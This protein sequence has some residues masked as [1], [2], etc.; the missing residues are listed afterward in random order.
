M[1]KYAAIGTSCSQVQINSNSN[2][3]SLSSSNTTVTSI[4]YEQK[5]NHGLSIETGIQDRYFETGMTGDLA[6]TFYVG[7]RSDYFEIPVRILLNQKII[8]DVSLFQR[9]G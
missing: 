4:T 8:G 3:F 9:F 6:G 1:G 5:I 2:L 7:A